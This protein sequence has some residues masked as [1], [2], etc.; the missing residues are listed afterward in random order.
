MKSQ[1]PLT[2]KAHGISP[3]TFSLFSLGLRAF[4]LAAPSAQHT[5]PQVSVCFAPSPPQVCTGLSV[6]PCLTSSLKY[7]FSSLLLT[8]FSGLYFSQNFSPSSLLYILCILVFASFPHYTLTFMREE[9]FLPVFTALSLTS[10]KD[11][12]TY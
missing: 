5:L 6:R 2:H 11:S 4:A 7:V 8:S 9:I 1:K 10:A 12:G 3:P